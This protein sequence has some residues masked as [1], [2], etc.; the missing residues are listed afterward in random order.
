MSASDWWLA[1][2]QGQCVIYDNCV[3]LNQYIDND[4]CKIKTQKS[5]YLHT[6]FFDTE[7]CCDKIETH[8]GSG[9]VSGTFS[10]ND[11]PNGF[12]M[13]TDE[14]FTWSTD[15]SS[16]GDG[17][18]LCA[19]DD[20]FEFSVPEDVATLAGRVSSYD[21][22]SYDEPTHF[23]VYLVPAYIAFFLLSIVLHVVR[24]RARQ[25][26]QTHRQVVRQMTR[27]N[28]NKHTH[29]ASVP[30]TTA[31]PGVA[32]ASAAATP[33]A[34]SGGSLPEQL[35]QLATLRDQGVL[36][37]A[38]FE[39]AKSNLLG[40]HP[41]ATQPIPMAYAITPQANGQPPMAVVQGMPM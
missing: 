1:E 33:H 27:R 11:G 29:P 39:A 38:Q 30:M 17:F 14:Y 8:Y 16:G 19:S 10:G 7:G 5:L 3:V 41:A 9:T 28:I 34:N 32:C 20:E 35:A 31:P 18:I 2:S 36:T 24:R 4:Y 22:S 37:E 23:T 25:T 40:T 26:G 13:D 12:W 15:G 21:G 6:E